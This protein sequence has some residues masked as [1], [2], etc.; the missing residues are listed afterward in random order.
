[1][2]TCS[3]LPRYL[4]RI[5]EEFVRATRQ[6]SPEVLIELL[7]YLGPRL[8]Q[9]WAETELTGPANLNVSW[10]GP[11]PSPAWLDIAR[12]YTEFWVHQQQIRDAVEH[13]GADQ[14]QLMHPVIDTFMRA[15]P[16]A[17]REQDR[18]DGT[19]VRFTVSGAAGGQ[20]DLV[21]SGGRWRMAPGDDTATARI[22]MD[23]H[24]FWRLATRGIT[25]AEG[26]RRADA[27][28]DT[29]LVDA[30]TALIAVVAPS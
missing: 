7:A 5:N 28:G 11:D 18:P 23:Q 15:L 19:T 10:A 17:L 6:C 26:R 30:A 24:D 12:D 9:V 8:D 29:A 20:W 3:P 22:T 2:G 16:Y 25:V 14:P 1:M 27:H 13:P 4:A 21:R